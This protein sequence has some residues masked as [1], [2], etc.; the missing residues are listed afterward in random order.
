MTII[1]QKFGGSSLADVDR[2]KAVAKRIVERKRSGTNLVVV[3]SAMGDT[4][5]RLLSMAREVTP[6]PQRRELDMLLTV[7][8]RTTM[9]LLSMA[10]QAL[11]EEA[12][13]FT[14][15]QCGVL[16]TDSH[17]RARIM[18]VRPFRVQDELR[19]GRI[20]IVAG[21]QGTSYKREI[22]T[23]GRGGSDLTAVALAGALGAEA[24]EIYSDVDGVL[25]AD[26]RIVSSATRIE[27]L[28][29]DEMQELARNGAKV[30]HRD[31]V[32]WAHREGV[33]LYA[34]STFADANATGTA[35]RVNPPKRPNPVVG[36]TGR[37]DLITVHWMAQP[38][39]ASVLQGTP[40]LAQ[41]SDQGRTRTVLAQEDLHE[42]ESLCSHLESMGAVVDRSLGSVTVVGAGLGE[43]PHCRTPIEAHF[44]GHP[45]VLTAASWTAWLPVD[46]VPEIIRVLHNK[47]LDSPA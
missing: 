26:P 27:E 11:G 1:V 18:E 44:D 19:R 12:I 28:S 32:A 25:T 38:E 2:L 47:L 22:T 17:S 16:T 8:E 41:L 5:N 3:V 39:I 24:C 33:A 9:A 4:T 15:S 43:A 23:L 6:E 31:A 42:H 29:F 46:T 37:R 13:S 21:F 30:L 7:G 34:R 20:V 10:I 14:G 36:I 40:T 45:N 35:V